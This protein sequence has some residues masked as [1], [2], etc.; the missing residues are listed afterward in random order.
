VCVRATAAELRL[1][2]TNDISSAT[3]TLPSSPDSGHGIAG[4]TQRAR[5]AGGAF[6]AG[7]DGGQWRVEAVLPLPEVQ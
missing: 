4:M 3:L 2:V 5:L 6:R 1:T 7:L